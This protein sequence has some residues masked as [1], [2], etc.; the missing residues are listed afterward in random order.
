V[1][2]FNISEVKVNK[3]ECREDSNNCGRR[4]SGFIFLIFAPDVDH[5]VW[6]EPDVKM[7]KLDNDGKAMISMYLSI[8][9]TE[10]NIYSGRN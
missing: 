3:I 2:V 1:L 4:V 9:I 8:L 6:C 5:L 10:I 7:S